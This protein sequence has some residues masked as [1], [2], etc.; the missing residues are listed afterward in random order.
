MKEV[1]ITP[2]IDKWLESPHYHHHTKGCFIEI[3]GRT[4]EDET[5]VHHYRCKV[6]DVETSKGGWEWGHYGGTFNRNNKQK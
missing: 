1:I 3:I 2:E 4:G 5:L 6:C